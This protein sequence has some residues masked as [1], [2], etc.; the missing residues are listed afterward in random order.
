M[1]I[2]LRLIRYFFHP[3]PGSPFDFYIPLMVV[4]AALIAL[5]VGIRVYIKRR[6]KEDKAFK[7]MFHSLPFA[8]YWFAALILGNLFGRYE[9]FPLLGARFVLFGTLILALY[10]L[11]K[12][13]Y[14][15]KKVYPTHIA[16]HTTGTPVQKK[17]TIEKYSRR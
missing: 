13:L 17:Y 15:Y 3:I 2:I 14:Q 1:N 6:G 7:K 16:H 10:T 5:G 11:G 12:A 9:R 8:C 4:A